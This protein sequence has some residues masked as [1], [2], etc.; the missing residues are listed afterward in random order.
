MLGLHNA[1]TSNQVV[2]T[3]P[4]SVQNAFRNI[5]VRLVSYYLLSRKPRTLPLPS[6]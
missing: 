1:L 5:A 3:S 4:S 2:C 6:K